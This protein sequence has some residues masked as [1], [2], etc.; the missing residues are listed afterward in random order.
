MSSSHA[1]RLVAAQPVSLPGV[2]AISLRDLCTFECVF[3]LFLYAGSIKKVPPLTD[4]DVT[5]IAAGVGML[6]GAF[7]LLRRRNRQT[8]KES[9]SQFCILFWW[10]GRSHCTFCTEVAPIQTQR[11]RK[12]R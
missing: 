8:S 6:W 9:S 3:M 11:F 4:F 2:S 12:W 10:Y 7:L 1:L 5:I